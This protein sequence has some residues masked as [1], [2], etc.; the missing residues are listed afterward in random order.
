M[1][2]LLAAA[3]S[4]V[5]AFVSAAGAAP[6]TQTLYARASGTIS[7]FAQDGGIIA[8]FTPGRRACNAVHVKQL[9]NGLKAD[10]PKP[11]DAHNVTCRWNTGR[12]VV[13][14][15]LA[16]DEPNLLWTLHEDSPLEFD[17]LVGAGVRDRRERR[18]QQL[19]HTARGAGLWLGGVAGD[20]RTLVYGVTSV[21]YEDEAGC[22]A[23]TDSCALKIVQ[24][25]GGVYRVT[26]G[27]KLR[28]I[29]GTSAAV[30]VAAAGSRVAYVE[31]DSIGKDGRPMAGADL[32]IEVVDSITGHVIS[33]ITPQ[34]TP[35]AI[36]LSAHV[37]ATLER[38]PL[39]LRLAWY[40]P[41]TGLPAGSAPVAIATSPALSV[42]DK[43][44]V[45]HVGRSIRGV[46]IATGRVRTFVTAAAPPIGLSVEGDRIAWAENLKHVARIRAFYP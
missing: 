35:I 45:F 2:V 29:P 30:A 10:L 14:L 28:L 36:A 13:P 46:E 18:F 16:Q 32:P 6:R 27:E 11:G 39:G 44:A 20:G 19:A 24:P 40:S 23:G 12:S 15:A 21:D 3:V 7:G 22:L 38:T 1:R 5:A 43:L 9:D 41:K 26:G 42:S 8:W 4:L 34:G 31:A 17:Y 37:L 25:G 33:S